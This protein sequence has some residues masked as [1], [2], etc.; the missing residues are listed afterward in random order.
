MRPLAGT[1][2]GEETRHM[3]RLRRQAIA[4]SAKPLATVMDFTGNAGRHKL[5]HAVVY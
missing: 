3:T 1:V 2:D 4:N 5:V